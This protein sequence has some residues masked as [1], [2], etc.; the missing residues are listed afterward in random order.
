MAQ[1]LLRGV[2][3]NLWDDGWVVE[4]PFLPMHLG[5]GQFIVM[6]R[7]KGTTMDDMYNSIVETFSEQ[8]PMVRV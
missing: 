4:G 7:R 2:E 6:V 8:I 1:V 5:E 3:A